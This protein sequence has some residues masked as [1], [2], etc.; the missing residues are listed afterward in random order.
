MSGLVDAGGCLTE[1]GLA[2]LAAALPGAAPPELA[3][4]V[5]SCAR[6]QDRWLKSESGVGNRPRPTAESTARRR[7]GM[8]GIVVFMLLFALVALVATL[9]YL[10]G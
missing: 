1:A 6:C 5:A 2:V 8:L 4:H 10:A 7:W 3:R 9:G